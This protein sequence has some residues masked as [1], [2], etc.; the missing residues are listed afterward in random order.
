M[1]YLTSKHT[2]NCKKNPTVTMGDS[3]TMSRLSSSLQSGVRG[4]SKATHASQEEH[5]FARR[6]QFPFQSSKNGIS[7]AGSK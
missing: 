6:K 3:R 1:L 4:V 2:F 7:S 5:R